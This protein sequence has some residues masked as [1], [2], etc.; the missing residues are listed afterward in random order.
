MRGAAAAQQTCGGA[1]L[2]VCSNAEQVQC[3][4]P[5]PPLKYL[6]SLFITQHHYTIHHYL[7]LFPLS[8]LRA[9]NE[10]ALPQLGVDSN[11]AVT[12]SITPAPATV[13]SGQA[14]EMS[15]AVPAGHP[16]M[17]QLLNISAFSIMLLQIGHH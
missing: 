17:E 15:G 9:R 1:Q 8:R 12:S 14:T 2:P 7:S 6:Q 13:S 4:P 5:P 10:S 16:M 11:R 3:C